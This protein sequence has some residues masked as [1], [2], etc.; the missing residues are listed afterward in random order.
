MNLSHKAVYVKHSPK[1]NSSINS[2]TRGGQSHQEGKSSFT[3]AAHE[4]LKSASCEK[5]KKNYDA[6]VGSQGKGQM[7]QLVQFQSE[8]APTKQRRGSLIKDNMTQ[9]DHYTTP[10]ILTNK[11]PDN[12]VDG[13]G[14]HF[15]NF[16]EN[17]ISKLTAGIQ[18]SKDRNISRMAGINNEI[19]RVSKI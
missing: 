19:E 5:K 2:H 7:K 8:Q 14:S 18:I 3:S 13:I 6:Y 1:G 9:I 4:I 12:G 11:R 17:S 16:G 15:V 10:M